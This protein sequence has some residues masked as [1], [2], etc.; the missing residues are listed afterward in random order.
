MLIHVSLLAP[1]LSLCSPFLC[2]PLLLCPSPFLLFSSPSLPHTTF[3]E[4]T[5]G[6]RERERQTE[7]QALGEC[8]CPSCRFMPSGQC[9]PSL[10]GSQPSYL[11]RTFEDSVT[12]LRNCRGLRANVK[13]PINIYVASFHG[14]LSQSNHSWH[15]CVL[16]HTHTHT[17]THTYSCSFQAQPLPKQNLSSYWLF[18]RRQSLTQRGRGCEGLD[19]LEPSLSHGLLV[20]PFTHPGKWISLSQSP[21]LHQ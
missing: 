17:H 15:I 21:F 8:A 13:R 6:Q 3:P 5:Q 9:T 18:L 7:Q 2:S 11:Q 1:C 20:L 10:L 4:L 16:I 12:H 14:L 19:K